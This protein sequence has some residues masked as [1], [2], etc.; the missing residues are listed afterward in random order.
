MFSKLRRN[1]T[2]ANVMS[3]LAFF[4]ALGGGAAYAANTVFSTDIVDQEV[5]NADLG[6]NAVGTN[7]VFPNSLIGADIKDKSL[8][9]PDMVTDSIGVRELKSEVRVSKSTE[10]AAGGEGD[11][12]AECPFGD[13]AIGG[14]GYWAFRSGWLSG[15]RN[16]GGGV[17][18]QGRNTGGRSQLLTAFAVCLPY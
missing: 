15:L 7:Q 3:S 8:T 11:A 10:V 13:Q 14:G 4:L 6:N 5:K 1:L 17:L 16:Y 18:A 12:R 9:G 2:Y